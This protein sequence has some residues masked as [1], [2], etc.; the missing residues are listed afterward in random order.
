MWAWVSRIPST[1]R[2]RSTL[3]RPAFSDSICDA[4]SGVASIMKRRPRSSISPSAATRSRRAGSRRASTHR[5]CVQPIC[6]TPPS[7]AI[8]RTT[9][10]TSSANDGLES[11]RDSETQRTAKE[12][13]MPSWSTPYRGQDGQRHFLAAAPHFAHRADARRA[14]VAARTLDDQGLAL[15]QQ[16][17][18]E[19]VQRLR[20]A[21]AARV[22]VIDEDLWL[23]VVARDGG[24]RRGA[25]PAQSALD[26]RLSL[27]VVPQRDAEV[28]A[29]AEQEQRRH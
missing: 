28:V 29:I 2:R 13:L 20:E 24:R 25:R 3:S 4:M 16:A 11:H 17:V 19:P 5:A 27:P 22:R 26:A 6:G 7:W 8:P 23:V 14:A 21:D 18:V 15:R 12:G 10:R 1:G 9:T